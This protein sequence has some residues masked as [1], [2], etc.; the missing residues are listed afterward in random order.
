[1]Y[2][3]VIDKPDK[4]LS[5]ALPMKVCPSALTGKYMATFGGFGGEAEHPSEALTDWP[6]KPLG[7]ELD[8]PFLLQGLRGLA[9]DASSA[10]AQ[11]ALMLQLAETLLQ[12]GAVVAPGV[13]HP[14]EVEPLKRP[15]K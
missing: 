2:R 4:T 5:S 11:A 13:Q 12:G 10:C 7:G 3:P 6:S 8:T 15:L 1:M 14:L 9:G